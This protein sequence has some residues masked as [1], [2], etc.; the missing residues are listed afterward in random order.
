MDQRGSAR[1]RLLDKRGAR[2]YIGASIELER[3]AMLPAGRRQGL[4]SADRRA[5][6]LEFV[7]ASAI[8]AIVAVVLY[9]IFTYRPV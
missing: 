4:D 2:G 7:A 9:M 8:F 3:C 6:V 5:V 1:R